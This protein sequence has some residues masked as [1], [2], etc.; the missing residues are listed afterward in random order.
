MFV[1][2]NLRNCNGAGDRLGVPAVNSPFL[3][4]A[5]N[6]QQTREVAHQELCEAL[7]GL[8]GG[9]EGRHEVRHSLRQTWSK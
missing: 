9:S 3:A 8:S 5:L 6:D 1:R 7:S 4:L 2:L